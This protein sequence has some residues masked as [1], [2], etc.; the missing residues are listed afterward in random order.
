MLSALI[1]ALLAPQDAI[2][3]DARIVRAA[4]AG[5]DAAAYLA[6]TSPAADR[7]VGV[8]CACAERVEIHR[9]DASEPSMTALAALDLPA[10]GTVEVRPGSALHLMLLGLKAPLAPGASVELV[11][12]F[13]R[14]GEA[15]ARFIAV[16]D[17][18]AA[19]AGA[20]PANR[21]P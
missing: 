12:R 9:F 7:L 10:G 4:P 2:R 8:A 19:W 3:L 15:T 11:L 13:E 6:I 20:M 21:A 14:A 5:E 1:L 18:R 17:T 16:E